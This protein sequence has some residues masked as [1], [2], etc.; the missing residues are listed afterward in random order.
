M[1]NGEQRATA[2]QQEAQDTTMESPEKVGKGKGKMPEAQHMEEDEE[3]SEEDEE[4]CRNT[5]N[6]FC[7]Q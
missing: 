5:C 4:V 3:E 2:V 7:A 1:E 6:D